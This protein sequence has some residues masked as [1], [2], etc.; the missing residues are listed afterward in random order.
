[1]LTLITY[2]RDLIISLTGI[3]VAYYLAH[4]GTIGIFLFIRAISFK[5]GAATDPSQVR[6]SGISF[7]ALWSWAIWPWWSW[8]IW[9]WPQTRSTRRSRPLDR[10]KGGGD[11]PEAIQIK[12]SPALRWSA[13]AQNVQ[14]GCLRPFSILRGNRLLHS[15]ARRRGSA[16][17][18]SM[19]HPSI[20]DQSTKWPGG[21]ASTN[22]YVDTLRSDQEWIGCH[23]TI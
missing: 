22:A 18:K 1:M 13:A 4:F 16:V 5:L 10:L 6:I 19:M 9:P 17:V 7:H 2:L 20:R 15:A 23:E 21:I 3:Y 8:A 12:E 14:K 11:L